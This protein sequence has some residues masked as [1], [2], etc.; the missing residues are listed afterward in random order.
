LNASGIDLDNQMIAENG[1][2][3]WFY[4]RP[5]D[6]WIALWVLSPLQQ[7]EFQPFSSDLNSQR[8]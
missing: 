7:G 3:G 8:K 5:A 1:L 4:P 2:H 6:Q